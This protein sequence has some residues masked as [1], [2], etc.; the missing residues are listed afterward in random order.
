MTC[1]GGLLDALCLQEEKQNEEKRNKARDL[2]V[3]VN[4]FLKACTNKKLA[5]LVRLCCTKESPAHC[6]CKRGKTAHSSRNTWGS[7]CVV[8]HTHICACGGTS[9]ANYKGVEE[10]GGEG[11]G[12]GRGGVHGGPGGQA[13]EEGEDLRDDAPGRLEGRLQRVS[14][15]AK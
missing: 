4:L 15:G 13:G 7:A 14:C 1:V 5:S 10:G 9:D 12:D 6:V 2:K 11:L 3:K 8:L